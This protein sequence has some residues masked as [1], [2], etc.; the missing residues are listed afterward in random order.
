MALWVPGVQE[1]IESGVR[2]Y[3]GLQAIRLREQELGLRNFRNQLTALKYLEDNPEDFDL[4]SQQFSGGLPESVRTRI[5]EVGDVRRNFARYMSNLTPQED[6]DRWLQG[7]PRGQELLPRFP[8]VTRRL[9]MQ[10]LSGARTRIHQRVVS[11]RLS[12]IPQTDP[13]YGELYRRAVLE[14]EETQNLMGTPE[15]AAM[16]RD[17]IGA[18]PKPL[19]LTPQQKARETWEVS[20]TP[21]PVPIAPELRPGAM[22]E[23]TPMVPLWRAT[24]EQEAQKREL[25][26]AAEHPERGALAAL[27]RGQAEGR[28]GLG[29]ASVSDLENFIR[30]H[31]NDPDM[32]NDVYGAWVELQRKLAEARRA[33]PGRPGARAPGGRRR[34]RVTIEPDGSRWVEDLD[35]GQKWWQE[36][37]PMEEKPAEPSVAPSVRPDFLATLPADLTAN[38]PPAGAT[39]D[40]ARKEI[41]RILI[42]AQRRDRR[43]DPSLLR[44]DAGQRLRDSGW[45]RRMVEEAVRLPRA[46]AKPSGPAAPA[47][48]GTAPRGSLDPRDLSR[49]VARQMFPGVTAGGLTPQQRDAIANRV[50][51]ILRGEEPPPP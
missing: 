1:G 28:G 49:R 7:S 32:A 12:G 21:V 8:E 41:D 27:R 14:D 17:M 25:I 16:I 43:L 11:S 5:N 42:E 9:G 47:A 18:G 3:G 6:F 10:R 46:P 35:T 26:A 50:N 20:Q 45:D 33:P 36:P 2:M 22:E 44:R 31:Q 24:A 34:T 39:A 23:P 19:A 29:G 48:P 38:P 37:P 13:N 4:I 51:R 40:D 15:G 30:R